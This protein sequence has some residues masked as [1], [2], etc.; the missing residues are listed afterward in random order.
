MKTLEQETD[1]IDHLEANYPLLNTE[2]GLHD[3]SNLDWHIHNEKVKDA[4]WRRRRLIQK[5]TDE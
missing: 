3:K 1:L 5:E 2:V 4:Y